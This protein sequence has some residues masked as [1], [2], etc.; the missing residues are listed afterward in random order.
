ML[1]AGP[2]VFICEECVASCLPLIADRGVLGDVLLSAFSMPALASRM[3]IVTFSSIPNL[4]QMGREEKKK[5]PYTLKEILVAIFNQMNEQFKDP[6]IVA[7]PSAVEAER[8]QLTQQ[9]EELRAIAARE[10][11]EKTGPLLKRISELAGP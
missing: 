3:E 5:G 6:N 11:E 2:T 4:L 9:V 1:I 7:G 10:L 8:L